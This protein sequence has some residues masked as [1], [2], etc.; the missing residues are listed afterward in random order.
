M[1][2]HRIVLVIDATYRTDDP[3]ATIASLLTQHDAIT[4]RRAQSTPAHENWVL[5]NE[6]ADGI[7]D[8]LEN[9]HAPE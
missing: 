9:A 8:I 4:V 3:T 2:E 6:S 1:N 7:I 5:V